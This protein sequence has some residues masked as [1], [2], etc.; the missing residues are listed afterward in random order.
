MK[1]YKLIAL[2][3]ALLLC[4]TLILPV[5]AEEEMVLQEDLGDLLL[6]EG[7]RSPA[8]IPG[9]SLLSAADIDGAA[10]YIAEALLNGQPEYVDVR[11]FQLTKEDLKTALVR[12]INSH[13]SLYHIEKSYKYGISGNIVTKYYPQYKNPD[14]FDH[15]AYQ[16]AVSKALAAI[17]PA[18]SDMQKVVAIHDYLAL[19]VEYDQESAATGATDNNAHSAYGALVDRYCVCEGYTLAFIELMQ[20]LEIPV[21]YVISDSMNHI[22]NMV[23]LDGEWYHV[24]I[25][26]D[27]P[28]YGASGIEGWLNH[29]YLLVGD[30]TLKSNQHYGYQP[31]G[32]CGRDYPGAFWNDAASAVQFYGSDAYYLRKGGT[33]GAKYLYRQSKSGVST[34]LMNL[35]TVTDLWGWTTARPMALYDGE[36]YVNDDTKV[37]A[38]SLADLS[39]HRTVYR[40]DSSEGALLGFAI[41]DGSLYGTVGQPDGSFGSV[42]LMGLDAAAGNRCGEFLFWKLEN[43]VLTITGTGEMTAFSEQDQQ[44]WRKYQKEITAVVMEEGVT[45]ISAHAFEGCYSLTAASLPVSLTQI[46]QGAFADTG[47]TAVNYAGGAR[48]WAK[49][50]G[51]EQ[52]SGL[53][54]WTEYLADVNGDNQIDESDAAMV[55]LYA[56]G[57]AALTA[58]QLNRADMNRDGKVNVLDAN[59]IRLYVMGVIADF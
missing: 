52:L 24:D 12:A 4:C 47:L 15:A 30:S 1:H 45:G 36:V 16:A 35:N 41:R 49:V 43:G 7:G 50:S 46:G 20:R 14:R 59:L 18:M 27:D 3:L 31:D 32:V 56:V 26:W 40:Q 48:K 25:T 13:P 44:P 54:R 9:I 58:D 53:V 23:Q 51:G 17:D 5:G 11:Q 28:I 55:R 37:V 2:L 29:A 21:T 6:Q 22:W 39:E 33:F 19:T 57:S 10:N 34:Q 38:I 42:R 8:P